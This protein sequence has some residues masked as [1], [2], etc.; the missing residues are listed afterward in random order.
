MF[1]WHFIYIWSHSD[2]SLR[3]NHGCWA[4]G[5]H[6][7]VVRHTLNCD[8]SPQVSLSEFNFF[9]ISCQYVFHLTMTWYLHSSTQLVKKCRNNTSDRSSKRYGVVL[10]NMKLLSF[11]ISLSPYL[12]FFFFFFSYSLFRHIAF[13]CVVDFSISYFTEVFST[14]VNILRIN[15]QLASMNLYWLNDIKSKKKKKPINYDWLWLYR[16]LFYQWSVYRMEPFVLLADCVCEFLN[17]DYWFACSA[18]Q[19]LGSVIYCCQKYKLYYPYY[20]LIS[21]IFWK[22][23]I[24]LTTFYNNLEIILISN[25]IIDLYAITNGH[26]NLFCCVFSLSPFTVTH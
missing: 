11:T 7:P 13:Q 24:D 19:W 17:F 20:D 16:L 9:S 26:L 21:R 3:H 6:T 14:C 8:T 1:T 22:H 2:F 12:Y 4:C 25:V 18:F 5:R 10:I 23:S 15:V